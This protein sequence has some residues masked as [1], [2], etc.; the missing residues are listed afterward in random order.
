MHIIFEIYFRR[1]DIVIWKESP[2]SKRRALHEGNVVG[3]IFLVLGVIFFYFSFFHKMSGFSL[4]HPSL[5]RLDSHSH[6]LILIVY[7]H[8]AKKKD[9]LTLQT[10]HDT[11]LVVSNCSNETLIPEQCTL[12]KFFNL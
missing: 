10:F 12:V 5:R 9:R 3:C 8:L 2:S 1:Y 7:P 4:H 6:D 11:G